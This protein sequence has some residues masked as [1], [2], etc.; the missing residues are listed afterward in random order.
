MGT[1][2]FCPSPFSNSEGKEGGGKKCGEGFGAIESETIDTKEMTGG[3]C[4]MYHC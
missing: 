3:G 2:K 4:G 1:T